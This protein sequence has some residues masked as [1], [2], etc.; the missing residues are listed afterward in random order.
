MARTRFQPEQERPER[1]YGRDDP[2]FKTEGWEDPVE[3]LDTPW[4]YLTVANF[5][6]D[7]LDCDQTT[8]NGGELQRLSACTGIPY[9]LVRD[10]LIG[11]GLS[12]AGVVKERNFRTFGDNPHDRWLTPEARQMNGGGG[13]SSIM[14]MVG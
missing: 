14:G 8:F 11:Y 6:E 7:K 10:E 12:L 13:G 3:D 5:V 4:E 1:R 2:D 9:I